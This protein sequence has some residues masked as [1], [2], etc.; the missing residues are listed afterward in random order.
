MGVPACLR[1]EL[2]ITL[3]GNHGSITAWNVK[4]RWRMPRLEIEMRASSVPTQ[5]VVIQECFGYSMTLTHIPM[6]RRWGVG[7]DSFSN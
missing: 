1:P 3:N 5:V 2:D 6:M 4:Y 7:D